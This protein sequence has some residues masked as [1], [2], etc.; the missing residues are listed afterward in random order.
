MSV[1]TDVGQV[2][3]QK[4]K[5]VDDIKAV[6]ADAQELLNKAR[7][8][9]AEGY[10]VIRTELEDRLAESIVRLQEVQEELKARARSAAKA[11]DIYVHENPWK[12]IG[13]VAA[14]G[15]IVGL[16]FSRTR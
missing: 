11:T 14:A 15:L 8:S 4:D 3:S 16:L 13:Y 6:M 7:T 9:G 2:S 1:E 5:L 12:S 10:S